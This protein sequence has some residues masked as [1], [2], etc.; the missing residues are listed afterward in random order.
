MTEIHRQ[1]VKKKKAKATVTIRLSVQPTVWSEDVVY[2]IGMTGTE[3]TSKYPVKEGEHADQLDSDDIGFHFEP[4]PGVAYYF[5]ELLNP[6]QSTKTETPSFTFDISGQGDIAI[7]SIACTS[8]DAMKGVTRTSKATSMKTPTP[9][10]TPTPSKTPA[11]TKTQTP[12]NEDAN[13]LVSRLMLTVLLPFLC[14]LLTATCIWQREL[15]LGLVLPELVHKSLRGDCWAIRGLLQRVGLVKS[16]EIFHEKLMSMEE[17]I[18]DEYVNDESQ[19]E[20]GDAADATCPDESRVELGDA[21]DATC[22]ES[23]PSSLGLPASDA[24]KRTGLTG[25]TEPAA[26][27]LPLIEP[28]PLKMEGDNPTP[29]GKDDVG[30]ARS[31]QAW[32]VRLEMLGAKYSLR[33]DH[34][35]VTNA[36]QLKPAIADACLLALGKHLLPKPWRAGDYDSMAV[37]FLD[38][39]GAMIVM[40]AGTTIGQLLTSSQLR[41]TNK[42]AQGLVV[43]SPSLGENARLELDD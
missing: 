5:F 13:A 41:V 23:P 39:E 18:I 21:A 8:E 1:V 20:L 43:E 10:K 35:S 37:E 14:I 26:I 3:L 25:L 38:M 17:V 32:A 7:E 30:F 6:E 19:V 4:T 28:A 22:P 24:P 33:I 29:R 42:A 40:S 16:D 11:P 9:K 12:A 2:I 15:L 27:A 31:W 36:A 34:S